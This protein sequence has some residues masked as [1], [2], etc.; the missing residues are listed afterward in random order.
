[1]GNLQGKVVI[2]TGAGQGLGEAYAKLAAAEGAYVVLNDIDEDSVTNVADQIVADGGRALGIVGDVTD[3]SQVTKLFDR[4][5][6]EFGPVDGVVCNAGIL[7]VG[8]ADHGTLEQVRRMIDVNVTGTW[9]CGVE[10]IRR[11][12]AAGRAGSIVLVTSGA[13]MGIQGSAA[14][15]MTKGAVAALTTCWASDLEGSG[16]RVNAVS[17]IAGTRMA[18][19]VLR[20]RAVDGRFDPH[21]LAVYP[22]AESNAPLV[23][24]LLSD[25][26]AD[27][28]GQLF[29]IEGD[30][31]SV[32]SR[33]ALL[34]PPAELGTPT[35]EAVHAAV[36]ASLG[37][38]MAP[39]GLLAFDEGARVRVAK[40]HH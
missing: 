16:I 19:E 36:S 35:V 29:R 28:V 9:L 8:P 30:A 5:E 33:P 17:P 40:R 12:R 15:G 4:A 6:A 22:T 34:R 1:M 18:E 32:I 26:S 25:W 38:L 21:E 39:P 7:M 11:M 3:E 37:N 14:Y 20:S 24:Y 27:L 31:L 23:L 2:I 13:A 10:A